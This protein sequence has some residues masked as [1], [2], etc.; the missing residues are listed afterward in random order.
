MDR[1]VREAD[2]S[3]SDIGLFIDEVRRAPAAKVRSVIRRTSLSQD[4][5]AQTPKQVVSRL[6]LRDLIILNICRQ[7]TDPSIR[8]VLR[9]RFRAWQSRVVCPTAKQ[10]LAEAE[11]RT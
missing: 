8:Q 6:R 9:R 7:S 1:L 5:Y 3:L 4:Y 2:T 10:L 11:T